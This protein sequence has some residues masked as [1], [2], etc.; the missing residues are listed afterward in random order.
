MVKI[1]PSLEHEGVTV[2]GVWFMGYSFRIITN[3]DKGLALV[4][5]AS[6]LGGR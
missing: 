4:R 2:F 6:N 3:T 1:F 5:A